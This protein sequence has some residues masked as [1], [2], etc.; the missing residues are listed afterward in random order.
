MQMNRY[1]TQLFLAALAVCLAVV[2][3]FAAAS[4]DEGQRI[5][6]HRLQASQAKL[7][8]AQKHEGMA[9]QALLQEHMKL[10]QETMEKMRATKPRVGMSMQEHEEWM[11][12]QQKLM[13]SML[14]QMMES[15]K[16]ALEPSAR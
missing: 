13:E 10:L 15:H 1:R 7:T 8:E 3:P 5:L 4:Q 2:A 6:N 9:R 16:L 14:S 12:Q 11:N